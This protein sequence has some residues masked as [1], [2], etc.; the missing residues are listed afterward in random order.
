M[1]GRIGFFVLFFFL[2]NHAIHR[3]VKKKKQSKDGKGL[4]SQ[5]VKSY[6][7]RFYFD[8]KTPKMKYIKRPAPN[9]T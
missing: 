2:K 3:K 5:Y 1:T 4:Y 6:H 9:N 7:K 8:K